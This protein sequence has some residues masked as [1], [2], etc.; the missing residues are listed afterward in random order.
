MSTHK[1]PKESDKPQVHEDLKGFEIGLNAFG[2]VT[3]NRSV[4]QLNA[5]LN[6]R[7]HDRKLSKRSAPK[8]AN[9]STDE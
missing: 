5:F 4:S 2:E 6:R 9:S 1:R 7:G 3:S 8:R